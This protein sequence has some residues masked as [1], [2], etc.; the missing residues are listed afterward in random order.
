MKRTQMSK[1]TTG[2]DS[3]ENEIDILKS[4]KNEYWLGAHEVIGDEED[5]KIYIIM[6]YM[7]NDSLIS[8]I[9]ANK[10]TEEL[11]WKLFRQLIDGL[12]YLHSNDII[13]RDIKPENLLVDDNENLKITD[14]GLSEKLKNKDNDISNTAGTNYYYCPES[15]QGKPFNGK[16]ADIWAWGITLY[17]MINGAY[18][19]NGKNYDWIK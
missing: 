3:I 17:Q 14:F 8:Y 16:K 2:V 7:K 11:I 1:L 4:I 18:P 5:D 15:L 19:F 13:H 6:D 9:K 12:E 10:L